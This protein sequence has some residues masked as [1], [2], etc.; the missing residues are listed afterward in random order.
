M[1]AQL[2]TSSGI[3]ALLIQAHLLSPSS[4]T[5]LACAVQC[6]QVGTHTSAELGKKWNRL[7][8]SIHCIWTRTSELARCQLD[9]IVELAV[10][11]NTLRNF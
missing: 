3:A 1:G 6:Q 7:P 4:G 8:A 11:Y 5:E 2:Y 10:H 9:V